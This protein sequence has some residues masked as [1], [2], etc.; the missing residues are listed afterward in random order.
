MVKKILEY[1]VHAERRVRK[2][3][4]AVESALLE[5]L[6]EKKL[7]QI[8]ISEL[9]ERA[10]INRKTFYNNYTSIDAVFASIESKLTSFIFDSLPR[11]LSPES[12][13]DILNLFQKFAFIVEPYKEILNQISLHNN[14]IPFQK[15][16]DEKVL[17][18]IEQNL[19]MHKI[20]KRL[21]PYINLYIV[22]GIFNIFKEWFSKDSDLTVEQIAQL[23]YNLTISTMKKENYQEFLE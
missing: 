14:L 7:N 13:I 23:A 21:T 6:K 3:Q 11:T 4:I 9:A 5:L 10:D 19:T 8:T 2:T 15:R 17:P 16:M 22:H 12:D 1:G 20:D 18:Y